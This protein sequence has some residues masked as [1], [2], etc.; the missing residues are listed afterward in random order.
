M[1]FVTYIGGDHAQHVG[2]LDSSETTISEVG[3]CHDLLD[4][5]RMWELLD[6]DVLGSQPYSVELSDVKVVAPIPTPRREIFCVGKN[7]REHALE[8]AASGFDSS[9]AEVEPSFPVIFTKSGG[10]VIGTDAPVLAH[11]H[12][13]KQL[14]YEAE[15]AIIIGRTG[16]NIAATEAMDF[17]WGYTLINDVTL[18]DRQRDHRQWLLG[19]SLDTNCPMGPWALTRDEVDLSQT[20]IECRVNGELRQHAITSDMIFDVPTI[21]E[22]LSAGLTLHPGDVIATGTPVGVGLGMNPPQFLEPGDV[23]EVQATGF[24]VLR[25]PIH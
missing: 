1:K 12:L 13:S 7:Y 6:E 8:F 11:R 22:T 24:G 10:S 20:I 17:V 15:L 19:K 3:Q 14:D 5:I 21:I 25:N 2:I 18:R 23:V 16:S 4:I 9:A